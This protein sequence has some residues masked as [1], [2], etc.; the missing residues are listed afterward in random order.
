MANDLLDH[1][2]EFTPEVA[3]LY[4]FDDAVKATV[5]SLTDLGLDEESIWKAFTKAID[6]FHKSSLAVEREDFRHNF[7]LG[8]IVRDMPIIRK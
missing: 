1:S 2:S 5:R 8:D 3:F 4:A 6:L 7:R